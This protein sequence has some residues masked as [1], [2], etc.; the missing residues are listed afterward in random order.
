MPNKTVKQKGG[1]GLGVLG[2][3]EEQPSKRARKMETSERPSTPAAMAS[4]PGNPAQD[5]IQAS[6]AMGS[7]TN[8]NQSKTDRSPESKTNSAILPGSILDI[9]EEDHR[10]QKY[11]EEI[12]MR[13]EKYRL[14]EEKC[15]RLEE[16][17]RLRE[18]II[19]LME[20]NRMHQEEMRMLDEKISIQTLLKA[21][22][23]MAASEACTPSIVENHKAIETVMKYREELREY[24]KDPKKKPGRPTPPRFQYPAEISS[25]MLQGIGNV[26]VNTKDDKGD[27]LKSMLCHSAEN[28]I[29]C[30]NGR[31]VMPHHNETSPQTY[32][33][34]GLEDV[35]QCCGF[36]GT[37]QVV[38][39]DTL[40]SMGPHLIV[41]LVD[42]RVLL[43]V[44]VKNPGQIGNQD[45]PTNAFN[46]I[47]A[48][49]Q[50]LNYLKAL[51][52]QGI[53]YPFVLLSTYTDTVIATLP[54]E[55]Q[56]YSEILEKGIE[57]S[58]VRD[59][60]IEKISPTAKP[61]SS[62]CRDDHYKKITTAQEQ[63]HT[64]EDDVGVDVDNTGGGPWDSTNETFD[65]AEQRVVYSQPFD[66]DMLYKVMTVVLES[67]YVSFK[68]S[69]AGSRPL[70]PDEGQEI[71]GAELCTLFAEGFAYEKVKNLK[72]TYCKAPQFTRI[73]KYHVLCQIGQGSPGKIKTIVCSTSTGKLFAAKLFFHRA[74]T[75]LTEEERRIEEAEEIEK[76]YQKA[77][78]ERDLWWKL[79]PNYKSYCEVLY[80]NKLPALTMPFFPP[81]PLN[82]REKAIPLIQ[83][84]LLNVAKTFGLHY[85]YLSW[86]NFGCRWSSANEMDI[87]LLGLGS[88]TEDGQKKAT[89]DA[90]VK[91]AVQQLQE[92][93]STAENAKVKGVIV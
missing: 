42:E 62:P 44:E 35:I 88:L 5:G 36:R 56:K 85:D 6:M 12:R 52:Q 63:N 84:R 39:E 54:N 46:S 17:I 47:T 55:T 68:E 76:N 34:Y 73:H 81:V 43:I 79:E 15:R 24:M 29:F 4:S 83:E 10:K 38:K 91:K 74:S 87:T 1:S 77:L 40:F 26:Q 20:K 70:L 67:S 65:Y 31:R 58:Q 41:V 33:S 50:T 22:P 37:F 69:K 86:R 30:K 13:D 11:L 64:D 78:R 18:D 53:D 61:P 82:E 16:K 48:G 92:T 21:M 3:E 57:E 66:I 23:S 7:S 27:L 89:A 71:M 25:H 51:K 90:L 32:L 19:A 45:N 80:M 28:S 60:G 72:V 49:G 75:K 59:K 14:L 93:M 9:S 8:E 2:E